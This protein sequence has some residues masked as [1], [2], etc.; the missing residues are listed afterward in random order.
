MVSVKLPI[1]PPPGMVAVPMKGAILLLTRPEY[2]AG[3]RR[4]KAW[5]RREALARRVN[6]L[7]KLD[8]D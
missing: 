5:R 8:N 7:T 6:N 4:G 2:L 1:E 3:L